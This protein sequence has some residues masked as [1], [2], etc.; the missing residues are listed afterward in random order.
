V[1][2]A[3]LEFFSNTCRKYT[4]NT[5]KHPSNQSNQFILYIISS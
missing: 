1:K 5:N 4:K 3:M 2:A